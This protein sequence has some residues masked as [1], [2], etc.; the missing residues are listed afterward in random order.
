MKEE[1]EEERKRRLWKDYLHHQSYF[2]QARTSLQHQVG[3]H[4]ILLLL[5]QVLHSYY[6]LQ[7]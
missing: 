1:R 2:L 6:L 5:K 7:W 3:P 4:M